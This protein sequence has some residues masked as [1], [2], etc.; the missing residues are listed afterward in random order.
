ML[1]WLGPAATVIK[2]FFTWNKQSYPPCN[3]V[4]LKEGRAWPWSRSILCHTTMDGDIT[5]KLAAPDAKVSSPPAIAPG[6]EQDPP[7]IG[8]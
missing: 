7:K 4:P 6:E 8:S 2:K 1:E 5:V 3:L